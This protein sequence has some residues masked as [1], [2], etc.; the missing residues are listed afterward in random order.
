MKKR[1]MGFKRI[2]WWA[3]LFVFT[4]SVAWIGVYLYQ[5]VFSAKGIGTLA[6]EVAKLRAD[7]GLATEIQTEVAKNGAEDSTS[8]VVFG[9]DGARAAGTAASN[10]G[11]VQQDSTPEDLSAQALF[12]YYRALAAKNTDMAGWIYLEDTVIDYPVMHTPSAPEK[13]LHLDFEGR[14]SFA[15]LPFLDALCDPQSESSNQIVYAHNMKTG[16]MFA[17]LKKYLEEEFLE[18][19]PTIWFDTLSARGE[20]SVIAVLQIRAVDRKEPSMLCYQPLDFTDMEN[21]NAMNAYLST[22]ARVKV[23][24]VSQN[25]GLLTLSTCATSGGDERLVIVAVKGAQ[26]EMDAQ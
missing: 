26:K 5:A 15:G 19:H 11:A 1:H 4:C 21:V 14:Y 9:E 8:D 10:V 16:Q 2:L 13:Y 18:S 25:D 12:A 23:G 3:A 7:A 20:Y 6:S 24:E 17:V 22:Y